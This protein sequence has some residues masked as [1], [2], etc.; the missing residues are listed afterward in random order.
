MSADASK[1]EVADVM[2]FL[3]SV[4]FPQEAKNFGDQVI[5]KSYNWFYKALTLSMLV[6]LVSHH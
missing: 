3:E 2:K 1:W 6:S 5:Y 4:G